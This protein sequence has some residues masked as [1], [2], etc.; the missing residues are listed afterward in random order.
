MRSDLCVVAADMR[1]D[2]KVM[3]KHQSRYMFPMP[4]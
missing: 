1:T 3:T 2:A 4:S